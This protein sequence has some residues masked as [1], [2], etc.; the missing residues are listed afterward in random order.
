M[1]VNRKDADS[2]VRVRLSLDPA[3]S[4]ISSEID[5][6]LTF[7]NAVPTFSGTFTRTRTPDVKLARGQVVA[8]QPWRLTSRV[9]A[10]PSQAAFQQIELLY[11]TEPRALKFAG[12]GKFVFGAHPALNATLTTRQADFDRLAALPVATRR[13]PLAVASELVRPFDGA[14]PAFPVKIDVRAD[15]ATLGGGAVRNLHGR[16]AGDAAGWRVEALELQGPGGSALRA[17]GGSRATQKAVSF[18]GPATVDASDSNALAAWLQGRADTGA[19]RL[20]SFRAAGDVTVGGG[21][22]VVDR[23]N[24]DFDRKA[25][26]GRLAYGAAEPNRAPKLDLDLK[27]ADLDIDGTVALLRSALPGLGLEMPT[28]VSLNADLGSVTY[29]GVQ[30]RDLKRS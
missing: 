12:A 26:S 8:N 14:P 30:A 6:T 4:P 23:L 5:G 19:A 22:F 21:R 27:A 29:A 3:D 11:G 2:G 28:E 16:L 7:A 24:V 15:V 17:T 1:T 25:I 13:L 10:T 18:A 9:E 20:G